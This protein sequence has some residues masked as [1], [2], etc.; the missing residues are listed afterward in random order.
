MLFGTTSSQVSSSQGPGLGLNKTSALRGH[1]NLTHSSLMLCFS[2]FFLSIS[3][4]I[5]SFATFFRFI[6]LFFYNIWFGSFFCIF[7][8]KYSKETLSTLEFLLC[9]TSC[10]WLSVLSP[11]C[12]G[13]PR[14]S[15]PHNSTQAI[16]QVLSP[17]PCAAVWKLSQ[18]N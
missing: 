6:I 16:C 5:I 14:F 18:S 11:S 4:W 3:F 1:L 7:H 9:A 10:L 13:L 17:Q 12:F 8:A 15:L 2:I